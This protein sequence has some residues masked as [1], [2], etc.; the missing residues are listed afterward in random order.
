MTTL[1]PAAVEVVPHGPAQVVRQGGREVDVG[2]AA[3]PVRAEE[4]SHAQRGQPGAGVG[5]AGGSMTTVTRARRDA[6]QLDALRKGGHGRGHLVRAGAE[7]GHVE[8]EGQG[9]RRQGVERG[10]RSR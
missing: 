3:D 5:S 7:A 9:A 1:R 4:S 10:R 8:D 6:D 2:H